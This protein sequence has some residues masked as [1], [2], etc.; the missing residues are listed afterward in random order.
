MDWKSLPPAK[1]SIVN[2]QTSKFCFAV[3]IV[4][5]TAPW[6]AGEG[7]KSGAA[8]ANI[9]P[10][11]PMW[12]AGYASRD[13]PADGKLNELW[14][15]ALVIEDAD[16]DRGLLITLDLIGIG[17]DLSV[18]ICQRLEKEYGLTRQSIAICT[19]HTHSG[20]V[21]RKNLAPMHYQLVPEPQQRLI[22]DYAGKLEQQ[23]IEIAGRAIESLQPC[24]LYRARGVASFAVNRRNNRPADKVPEQR[25]TGTLAGPIDH[26]VPVLA[27]KNSDGELTSVV[28]GY[29]CHATVLSGYQWCGDYPGYA[30]DELE[31]LHPGC[32]AMFWAGC[33][34]DQNPL[35]RRTVELARH[36]GRQLAGAVDAALLT[37]QVTQ[38]EPNLET[39]YSE[40]DLQLGTLPTA[41]EL[42]AATGAQN[43]YQQARARCCWPRS[44]RT[45]RWSKRI[46]TR[47]LFG[48]SAATCVG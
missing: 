28:F 18:S 48:N 31:R 30:Q 17:R 47:S 41:D 37:S 16:G 36:Y 32:Q 4:V 40:I 23:L 13:R 26:D 3:L 19:S 1:G 34:G 38:I 29:A 2:Q 43:R 44:N 35:P 12:M 15:K 5:F 21:V 7:W 8:R 46:L 33:G 6:A 22:R 10:E 14:A 25:A 9:T 42:R 39:G 24:T 20:P 27:V 11:K 45:G